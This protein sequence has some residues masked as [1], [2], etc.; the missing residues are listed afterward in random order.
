MPKLN[1]FGKF[2]LNFLSMVMKQNIPKCLKL[3]IL[4]IFPVTCTFTSSDKK[5]IF[6]LLQAKLIVACHWKTQ[7]ALI[8]NNGYTNYLI[9]WLWKNPHILLW[10]NLYHCFDTLYCMCM[11]IYSIYICNLYPPPPLFCF[12]CFVLIIFLITC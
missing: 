11:C 6:C 1:F 8:L 9:A 4:N 10:E 7:K 3:S 2:F 12:V 5:L